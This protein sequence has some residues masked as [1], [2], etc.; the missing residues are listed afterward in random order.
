MADH[1]T[2]RQ[3]QDMA[4]FG[5]INKDRLMAWLHSYLEAARGLTPYPPELQQ[6]DDAVRTL[7]PTHT[8]KELIFSGGGGSDDPIV[9]GFEKQT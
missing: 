2:L 3:L 8:Q 5:Q 4:G 6:I 9:T 7:D 1:R